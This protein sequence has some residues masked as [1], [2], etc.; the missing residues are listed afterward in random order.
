MEAKRGKEGRGLEEEARRGAAERRA[1]AMVVIR[2]IC[3]FVY[4]DVDCMVCRAYFM[5]TK[6]NIFLGI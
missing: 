4:F 3:L 5:M 2:F 6:V 1:R